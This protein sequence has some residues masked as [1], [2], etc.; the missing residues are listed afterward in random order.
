MAQ[1]ALGA[2]SLA[3]L[4]VLQLFGVQPSAFA[5]HSY[6][7]LVA[8]CAAGRLDA[9]ALHQL[10]RRRGQL[11][12]EVAG[13]D[14]AM[15]AVAAPLARIQEIVRAEQLDL[16]IANRNA[17]N[18]AVLSGRSSEIARAT[19]VFTRHNLGCRKLSVSA[20]FHSPLV[21]GFRQ[22]FA[23]ALAKV[24]FQPATAPVFANT[25]AHLTRPTRPRPGDCWPANWPNRWPLSRKSTTCIAPV[26][27]RFWR[28]ARV[29]S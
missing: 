16:T 4:R 14:G 27:G 9:A 23:A 11:M 7:E 22:P 26:C 12:A 20:A 18:Q 10:S 19:E 21:A 13:S 28:L 2:V 29:I 3:A 5:G 8:L 1:P 17:P 25:T 24:E 15:L 6:G